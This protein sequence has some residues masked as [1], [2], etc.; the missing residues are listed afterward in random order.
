M[1]A[2]INFYILMIATILF[3]VYYVFS[4]SPAAREKLIGEKAYAQCGRFRAA[5]I[6]FEMI[7]VA[8]Y[9][10]FSFY[11]VQSPL[12]RHFP[13]PWWLSVVI[14]L[15]VGLPATWLMLIGMKDAGPEAVAP[16]K[17]H[18][19]YGGIYRT[20]RHPQAVGEVFLFPVMAML[21]HSPFLLLF[22]LIYFPIYL[23][24][25]WAEDQDLILRFGE[26]FIKYARS[27]PAFF[28]KRSKK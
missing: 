20:I 6:G 11:P 17:E 22:S 1:I 2:W 7:T 8:N 23:L 19:M 25:C 18:G 27:V 21:V 5:A 15:A 13:W 26:P 16:K 10:L 3:T 12:P 28:P 9:I 14:G 24:I 4:V